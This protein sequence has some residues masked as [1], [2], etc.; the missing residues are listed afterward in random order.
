MKPRDVKNRSSSKARQHSKTV[1][2]CAPEVAE[3]LAANNSSRAEMAEAAESSSSR[4]VYSSPF[5]VEN[6]HA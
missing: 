6:E 3:A 4:S 1:T 2:I 5:F